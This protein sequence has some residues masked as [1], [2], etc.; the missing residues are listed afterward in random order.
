MG[1]QPALPPG[2]VAG[3]EDTLQLMHFVEFTQ[4]ATLVQSEVRVPLGHVLLTC[5]GRAVFASPALFAPH[6]W[7]ALA[8][9]GAST[10][11]WKG[12]K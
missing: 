1:S 10:S 7:E 8:P 6:S 11:S 4:G 12:W 9:L 5:E 3:G 2:A